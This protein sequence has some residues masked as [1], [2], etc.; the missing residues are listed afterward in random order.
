[1][2]QVD[3][4]QV[5][6]KTSLTKNFSLLAIYHR[7]MQVI[8]YLYSRF[9]LSIV[10][11]VVSFQLLSKRADYCL[12][13]VNTKYLELLV[14]CSIFIVESQVKSRII[15][16]FVNNFYIYF[17]FLRFSS[18][19]TIHLPLYIKNIPFCIEI[20]GDGRP[21]I[22]YK[23]N[24][25]FLRLHKP[26]PHQYCENSPPLRLGKVTLYNSSSETSPI[27]QGNPRP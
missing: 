7:N 26:H 17:Q 23:L 2:L 1:M 4:L 15:L 19:S 8:Q 13:Q 6:D 20:Y 27:L 11:Q 16:Y 5:D 22:S 3:A 9:Y 21:F 12:F 10:S 25:Q 14:D 18:A 24:N